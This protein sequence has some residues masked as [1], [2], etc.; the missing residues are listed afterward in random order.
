MLVNLDLVELNG[1][2]FPQREEMKKSVAQ[3]L[4]EPSSA[5]DHR[6]C[7]HR[8]HVSIIFCF[9]GV[10]RIFKSVHS[11]ARPRSDAL[12]SSEGIVVILRLHPRTE[13]S[14]I[15]WHY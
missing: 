15:W 11:E 2:P 3:N 4:S 10:G 9:L 12:L 7:R 13:C 1:C 8:C 14:E 6:R 5:R